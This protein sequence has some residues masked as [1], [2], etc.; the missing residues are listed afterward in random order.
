MKVML[1]EGDNIKYFGFPCH[2]TTNSSYEINIRIP[3][4]IEGS[5]K[6]NTDLK[7]FID[8]LLRYEYSFSVIRDSEHPATDKITILKSEARPEKFVQNIYQDLN[9]KPS[10]DTEDEPKYYIKV[11]E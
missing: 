10:N 7:S 5:F 8:Y 6:M 2:I 1:L 3:Q 11:R 4:K 9:I